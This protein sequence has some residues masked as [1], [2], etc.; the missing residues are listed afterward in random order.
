MNKNFE[1]FR[2]KLN[3]HPEIM[4]EISEKRLKGNDIQSVVSAMPQIMF[5][6]IEQYHIWLN[7][8][9]TKD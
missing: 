3:S 4:T 9:D 2:N 1:D 7:S 5:D 8:S 6:M